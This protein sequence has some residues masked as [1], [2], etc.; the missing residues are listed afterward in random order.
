[1]TTILKLTPLRPAQPA[2]LRFGGNKPP[3]KEEP[4]DSCDAALDEEFRELLALL[5]K[6]YLILGGAVLATLLAFSGVQ[7]AQQLKDKQ[8]PKRPDPVLHR[9][10]AQVDL[11]DL[12]P[13]FPKSQ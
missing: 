4:L 6:R 2:M 5:Q 13:R 10:L 3:R 11:Q 9:R 12:Y 7:C 8:R 1:M